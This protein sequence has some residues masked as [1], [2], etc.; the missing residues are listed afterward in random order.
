MSIQAGKITVL[1]QHVLGEVTAD[2]APS[3]RIVNV[4]NAAVPAG[5][6]QH[7]VRIQIVGAHR[8][9]LAGA[10]DGLV[11]LM[12]GQKSILQRKESAGIGLNKTGIGST[13]TDF[14]GY[15]VCQSVYGGA[16]TLYRDISGIVIVGGGRTI[17]NG[18]KYTALDGQW[19]FVHR[20]SLHSGHSFMIPVDGTID[21]AIGMQQ[22]R[23]SC[24][25]TGALVQTETDKMLHIIIIY[26][27]ETI[28]LG[29]D[30]QLLLIPA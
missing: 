27:Y 1:H 13:V 7:T 14:T 8:N 20:L 17:G 28:I 10:A 21:G 11:D 6:L 16:G 30:I 29:I 12:P 18:G 24:S 3:G 15:M 26:S 5:K 4:Q 2:D 19:L 9:R 22:K 23:T 25:F